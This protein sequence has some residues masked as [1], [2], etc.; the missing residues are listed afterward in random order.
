VGTPHA[1]GRSV[2]RFYGQ[3]AFR[4][5][6]EH[7]VGHA[8]IRTDPATPAGVGAGVADREPL[9][10]VCSRGTD[11]VFRDTALAEIA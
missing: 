11:R 9:D 6:R 1:S 8:V 3:M 2:A 5:H 7:I 4:L 10:G